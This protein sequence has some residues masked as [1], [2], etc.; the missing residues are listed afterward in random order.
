[1]RLIVVIPC[2][3]TAAVRP[4]GT[5]TGPPGPSAAAV[6]YVRVHGSVGSPD[7]AGAFV[8]EAAGSADVGGAAG[9]FAGGGAI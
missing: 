1:V 8:V 9:C 3:V 6:G 4:L 2:Q 7:H 5:L